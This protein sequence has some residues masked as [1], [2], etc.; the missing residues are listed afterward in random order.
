MLIIHMEEQKWVGKVMSSTYNTLL[1]LQWSHIMEQDKTRLKASPNRKP[2][3][4]SPHLTVH[5]EESYTSQASL[6]DLDEMP[7]YDPKRTNKPGFSGKRIKRGLYRASDG[8][9]IN[10]SLRKRKNLSC[11]QSVRVCMTFSPYL[12]S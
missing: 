4:V 1:R 11:Q 3:S 5:S 8:R 7:V 9:L 12:Q 6:L 2:L 10:L